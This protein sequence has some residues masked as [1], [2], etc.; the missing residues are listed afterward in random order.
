MKTI[1]LSNTNL[2]LPRVIY[3]CW[4]LADDP[5]GHEPAHVQSKIEAC[6]EL[7]I[8]AFDHAD[9]YGD[10]RCER[11]FGDALRQSPGLRD[12]MTLVSKCDIALLSGNRPGHVV[13]HYDTSPDHISSSVERSLENLATDR[14][15][16]LLLHRP[17][18]LMNARQTAAALDQ[19][20]REG[21]VRAVGV[22]NFTPSQIE[23]LEAFLEAP[24]TV[25]QIELSLLQTSPLVDGSLDHCQR[26][27]LHPMAWSPLGGGRLFDADDRSAVRVCEAL[28]TL[29]HSRDMDGQEDS[30][31]QLALAWVMTLPSDPTVIIGSNRVERIEAAAAAADIV[32][33]RQ[34]WFTLYEAALGHEVP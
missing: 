34:E 1:R 26:T 29:A 5:S 22:S 18:L 7:G 21:K 30:L 33:E 14:L 19:L 31:T 23:L 15:D 11:I 16:L 6:L 3:G 8:N 4:R 17:D 32:L 27:A 13:K 24:L 2:D 20:I 10:Y 12:Q 9:I 25:N 28:R